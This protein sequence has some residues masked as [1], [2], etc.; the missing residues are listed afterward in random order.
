MTE[1]IVRVRDVMRPDYIMIDGM[2]TVGDAL[3]KMAAANAEMAVVDKRDEDDEY[4]VLLL[5]NIVDEILSPNRPADRI[6]VYEVMKKPVLTVRAGMNI[7][8]CARLF[9]SFRLLMAPVV[10]NDKLVGTVSYRELAYGTSMLPG[11]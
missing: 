10:S 8:Y 7:R 5:V 4:G 9:S 6:N 11:G 3:K 1:T 2:E